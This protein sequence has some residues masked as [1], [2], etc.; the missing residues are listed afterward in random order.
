MFY[1]LFHP[2]DSD[3]FNQSVVEIIIK[4][5]K[6][7]ALTKSRSFEEPYYIGLSGGK[8]FLEIYEGLSNAAL[9]VSLP[10]LKFFLIDERYVPFNDPESNANNIYL[11]FLRGRGITQKN[12]FIFPNTSL[13][14]DECVRVYEKQLETILNNDGLDLILLGMGTDT[15]IAS[16]FPPLISL[17]LLNAYGDKIVCQTVCNNDHPVKQR[18][19]V[20]LKFLRQTTRT[21]LVFSGKEK[22]RA[23]HKLLSSYEKDVEILAQNPLLQVLS[24]NQIKNRPLVLYPMTDQLEFAERHEIILFGAS[25]NLAQ[26]KIFP[27]LFTLFLKNQ[28]KHVSRIRCISRRAVTND[29][30]MPYL[31]ACLAAFNAMRSPELK[32][33][34]EKINEFMKLLSYYSIDSYSNVKQIDSILD[35]IRADCINDSDCKLIVYLATPPSSYAEI[36]ASFHAALKTKDE[37]SFQI[38]AEKPFGDSCVTFK[39]LQRSLDVAFSNNNLLL[40]DH[41]LGKIIAR[42][43]LAFRYSFQ[44]HYFLLDCNNIA[45][46]H[47]K[48]NEAIGCETRGLFYEQTGVVRDVVQNHVLQ[49]I[50][51]SVC[52]PTAHQ[53]PHGL[54]NS[55][56]DILNRIERLTLENSILGQYTESQLGPAYVFHEGVS[57][58]SKV[59][60][61]LCTVTYFRRL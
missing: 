32:L 24:Q 2:I 36:S 35:F 53:L 28:L 57:P 46:I 34:A 47:I 5:I 23:F 31:T 26:A 59:P 15:H 42:H 18:L 1:P 8:T 37:F 44:H 58:N 39:N 45:K 21:I 6:T 56:L 30:F 22:S 4:Q 9:R 41:Y 20:S 25:G 14:L 12:A 40:I 16:W 3:N 50:A 7:I 54:K 48:L 13:P 10:P 43:M 49:L 55:K 61:Y 33:L 38:I 11:S 51:L 17:D 19:T 29:T 27:A 52:K 60:T